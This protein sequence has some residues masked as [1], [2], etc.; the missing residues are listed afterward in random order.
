MKSK[1][2]PWLLVA[3]AAVAA[4]VATSD[5]AGTGGVIVAPTARG[6]PNM[7]LRAVLPRKAYVEG[8][9][10][11]PFVPPPVEVSPSAQAQSPQQSDPRN[12][13]QSL[14]I[15]IGKQNDGP[16]GWSV[17]LA[18]NEQTLIARVG[19]VLDDGYRIISISPPTMILRHVKR[20]SRRALDIGEAQ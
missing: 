15:V 2:L 7:T 5:P 18:R 12:V 9:N 13:E 8:S 20:D 11:D 10:L 19:D 1:Q 17:F 4:L 14:W 3:L 6:I 16:A